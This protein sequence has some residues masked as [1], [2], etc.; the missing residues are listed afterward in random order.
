M[1]MTHQIPTQKLLLSKEKKWKEKKKKTQSLAEPH[2]E[3]RTSTQ[4]TQVKQDVNQ[5]K[6]ST[7][8]HSLRRHL[9]R[10][11]KP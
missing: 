8:K 6:F 2:G 1:I 3:R 9:S 10:N 5:Y 11:G 4:D 7:F